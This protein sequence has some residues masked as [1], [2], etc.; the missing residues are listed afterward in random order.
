MKGLIVSVIN[1]VWA[2]LM[3]WLL[4]CYLKKKVSLS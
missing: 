3:F 4:A 2:C 1:N